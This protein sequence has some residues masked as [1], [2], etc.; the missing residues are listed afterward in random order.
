MLQV[1]PS[2]RPTCD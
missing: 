1:S 2:Y